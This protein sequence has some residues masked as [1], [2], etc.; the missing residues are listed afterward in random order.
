M[1]S[2]HLCALAVPQ[3]WYLFAGLFIPWCFAFFVVFKRFRERGDYAAIT[4]DIQL[5]EVS[6]ERVVVVQALIFD[7]IDEY[8]SGFVLKLNDGRALYFCAEQLH[9][10]YSAGIFPNTEVELVT[11]INS[12]VQLEERFLGEYLEPIVVN[13]TE[14]VAE[15]YAEELAINRQEVDWDEVFAEAHQ[16]PKWSETDLGTKRTGE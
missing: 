5:G 4:R 11:S 9:K 13:I 8:D 14:K 15:F 10:A 6:F 2:R 12:G 3:Q 1:V 7:G 16:N